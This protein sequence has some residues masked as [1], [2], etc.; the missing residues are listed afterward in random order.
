MV[1]S[2]RCVNNLAP[3]GNSERVLNHTT[4]AVRGFQEPQL[5]R[6]TLLSVLIS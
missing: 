1:V 2:P 6:M 3:H 4:M 5:T